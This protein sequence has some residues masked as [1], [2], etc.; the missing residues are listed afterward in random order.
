M[1]PAGRA[2][3]R[4]SRI[5]WIGWGALAAATLA[6]IG[7]EGAYAAALPLSK[8]FDPSVWSEVLDTRYGK[9]ALLRLA[10]LAL[11]FPLLR[12]LLHADRAL[13]RW[14][15]A[16]AAV[17]AVG[18]AATP[19]LGGHAS[20]GEHVGL[21][22]VSDTLHV[23]A[24]AC[25]LGGLVMLVAVVLVT[26]LPDGLRVAVNRFSS[27]ALGAITVLV[28]TGA[29][30]AWR[31]VGSLEALRDT[32]F[33]RLL[34][35][36]L[37]L[38]AAIVVAAAFSREIVN[39]QFWEPQLRWGRRRDDEDEVDDT[40]DADTHDEARVGALV[41]A[42]AGGGRISTGD[43]RDGGDGG[44]DELD[45]DDESVTDESE[46]HRLRRAVSIEV[47]FAIVVL[48]IVSVL[49]NTAPARTVST[50]PVSFQ[51]RTGSVFA[52]VT[53]APG[54]AGRNDIHFTA[55]TTNGKTIEDVQVQLT[56][57]GGDL[58]P[59]D[60]PL[61]SLGPGHYYAPRFDIPFPGD[62]RMVARVRLGATDE[63]VLT[64]V[65]TLR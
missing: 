18:L 4:A 49:V 60:V 36:K 43:G 46:A 34:L 58:A 7:L 16:P 56:R 17:V 14:W 51:M 19:G 50:A 26:P 48:A 27:L 62:W 47:L 1:F 44:A 6:A 22:L 65:F 42:S 28:V 38:V 61:R 59:F 40:V 31:Q 10:L 9:V 37:V 2:I 54:T 30:Q 13:P 20:T 52:D 39:R 55:L 12:M 35:A 32:D 21:A 15:P 8:A 57:P 33:G 64:K 45:D 29:F 24:M 25:W 11:A 53:I 41:G 23:L 63:V 5:V 3:R